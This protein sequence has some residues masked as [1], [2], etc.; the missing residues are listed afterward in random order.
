VREEASRHEVVRLQ[1]RRRVAPVHAQRHA[2]QHV[3][4]PLTRAAVLAEQVRA[5]QRA[6]TKVVKVEVAIV[7]QRGLDHGRE[8]L[9]HRE[10]LS[11]DQRRRGAGERV[12]VRVER[13]ERCHETRLRLRVQA[14]GG[15]ARGETGE[16][17]VHRRLVR[18]RLRHELVHL[19]LARALV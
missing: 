4:R 17:G 7:P 12:G 11:R 2:H 15:D 10:H 6:Q 5:L 13:P 14:R 1:D 8:L 16:V 18:R 19:E 3:L 9:G